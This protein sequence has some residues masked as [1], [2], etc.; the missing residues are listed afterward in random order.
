MREEGAK[1][2]ERRRRRE[3]EEEKE[4]REGAKERREGLK[5]DLGG[6]GQYSYNNTYVWVGRSTRFNS[7]LSF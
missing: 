6:G 4:R 1:D 7:F 2:N 5:R 3:G